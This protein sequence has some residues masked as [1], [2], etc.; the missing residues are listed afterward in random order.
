[1]IIAYDTF[2]L[3][4]QFRN[5]GIYEYAKN[6][7]GEFHALAAQD[8]GIAIRYFVSPGYSDDSVILRARTE[9]CEPA[10]TR[11][12]RYGR[13]WRLGLVTV[14]AHR[15]DA[16]L[17][18]TPSPNIFPLG[19]IPV[20]VTIHDAMPKRLP[21]EL[22]ERSTHLRA[23]AWIAAKLSR[24]IITDSEHS[25][26]DLVELYDL[27]PDKVSVVYLGYDRD[28]FN[29]SPAD[30]SSQESLLKRLGI[31]RPY[32]LHH[33]MVQLRKN[34]GRLIRAHELLLEKRRNLNLQLVLAG[35][36]GLGSEQIRQISS[37]QVQN[38]K[39]V[40]TGTLDS[41]DLA[42]LIK[43]AMLCV[44]PSLYEGFCL[45]MVEAMACGVPTVVANSSCL[46]EV[47][48]GMLRYFNPLS[49]EDMAAT[50]EDVLDHSDL[51]KEL[52][53]GGLKRAA[54]FSWQRCAQQTVMVL[55]GTKGTKAV[56]SPT[57]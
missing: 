33:G 38:G 18:F 49:E 41:R 22:I 32:I 13:L 1:L 11:L 28:T 34:V 16:D 57:V 37:Q 10:Y 7:L 26:K 45:P 39:V 9:H 21:P 50:I 12:L 14:A 23:A 31:R 55:R 35:P 47:S 15:L 3:A 5:V 40:F 30:F 20:A 29:A 56:Y 19:S 51:Q 25:K 36:F 27:P 52:V 6:L 24:T 48:G 17:I 8:S 44:I 54:E 4:K 43:G 53:N 42:T 46:P 2:F